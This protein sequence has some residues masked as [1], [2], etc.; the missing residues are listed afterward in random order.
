MLCF[1]ANY[2]SLVTGSTKNYYSANMSF[3]DMLADGIVRNIAAT[4]AT[5]R[6]A[7][8]LITKGRINH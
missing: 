1:D 2:V 3:L 8:A 5:M 6:L 4:T 7:Q